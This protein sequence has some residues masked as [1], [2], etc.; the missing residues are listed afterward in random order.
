MERLRNAMST[1]DAWDFET[2]IRTSMS[3][4]GLPLEK[5]ENRKKMT[6]AVQKN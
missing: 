6:R 3:S 2:S 5:I 4:F 1:I